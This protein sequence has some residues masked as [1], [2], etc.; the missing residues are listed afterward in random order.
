V[1]DDPINV[2]Y[3]NGVRYEDYR[4]EDGRIVT[5]VTAGCLRC[6][7]A[8]TEDH[9]CKR[10]KPKVIV[11]SNGNHVEMCSK[12]GCVLAADH[13]DRGAEHASRRVSMLACP[14]NVPN[15]GPPCPI[16]D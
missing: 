10:S 4:L 2:W 16:C 3:S 6:G 13:I 1:T 11:M 8:L 12:P 5:R 14:H 7:D 9:E 15:F